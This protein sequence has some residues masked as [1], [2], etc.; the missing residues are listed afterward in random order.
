LS[1]FDSAPL[2]GQVII[3]CA[4]NLEPTRPFNGDSK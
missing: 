3:D 2:T 4:R 1:V